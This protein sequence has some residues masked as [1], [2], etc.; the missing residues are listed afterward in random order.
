MTKH[1]RHLFQSL[2]LEH[3][4]GLELAPDGARCHGGPPRNRR[5]DW[6]PRVKFAP[7]SPPAA[8]DIAQSENLYH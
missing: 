4:L 3:S 7:N 2:L 8:A 1:K 6:T 5:G